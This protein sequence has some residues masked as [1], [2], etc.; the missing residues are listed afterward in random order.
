MAERVA[1]PWP[2]EALQSSP[3]AG[4]WGGVRMEELVEGRGHGVKR[5]CGRCCL[6]P[7]LGS[8]IVTRLHKRQLLCLTPQTPIP[9][10]K[11]VGMCVSGCR[12]HDVVR[13]IPCPGESVP[14][15]VLVWEQQTSF[16]QS[17]DLWT[18]LD[19]DSQSV[20]INVSLS[21]LI[22]WSLLD[23]CDN[24]QMTPF[25]ILISEI[26]KKKMTDLKLTEV[27]W[28]IPSSLHHSPPSQSSC[29]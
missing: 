10:Q 5:G 28:T 21:T 12:S 19:W 27:Q 23:S 16:H 13:L 9:L 29:F 7:P 11:C 2:L 15:A 18:S 3:V 14:S 1:E 20:H 22:F 17:D 4:G 26:K 25:V 24:F 8:S 6:H